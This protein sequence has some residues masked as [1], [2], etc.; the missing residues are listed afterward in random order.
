M[1]IA[2]NMKHLNTLLI[3]AIVFLQACKSSPAQ[4]VTPVL[5]DDRL[6]ETSGIAASNTHPGMY[7]VHNDSGDTSRF[8]A[9][10]PDGKLKG[11][12]YY[13]ADKTLKSLGVKDCEDIAVSTGP[14]AGASYVY[15]GDIGDNSAVRKYITVYRI[16][17]PALSAAGAAV[18]TTAEALTLQYP[19]GARDAETLMADPIDKLLYIV[20][21]REDTVRIYTTPLNFNACDTLVLSK[22]ASLYLQGS[23]ETKWIVAGDIAQSG[24]QVLLKSYTKVYYWKRSSN[25]EPIWQTLLRSPAV[26]PY[27][28]ELQGEAIGFTT[29]A[30]GY[31]TVGEG[32]HAPVYYYKTP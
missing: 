26:L 1:Y 15:I 29:D 3:G 17:E 24:Q 14:E 32:V 25:A 10:G 13:N 31:Y 16:K 20:S 9:I 5:D 19:D 7:Y 11:V 8:F 27:T 4:T 22:R 6:N 12:F 2:A 23:G 21:K 18:N 30:T 28:L